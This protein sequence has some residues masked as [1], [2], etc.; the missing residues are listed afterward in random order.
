[1]INKD[2]VMSFINDFEEPLLIL[3]LSWQIL[4]NNEEE[5][6]KFENFKSWKW[7]IKVF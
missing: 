6:L 5:G 3:R 1:M 2:P 7:L 4:R